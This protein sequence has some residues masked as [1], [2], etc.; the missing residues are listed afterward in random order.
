ML[1]LSGIQGPVTPYAPGAGRTFEWRWPPYA[2]QGNATAV[3]RLGSGTF[4]NSATGGTGATVGVGKWGGAP[5]TTITHAPGLSWVSHFNDRISIQT[6]RPGGDLLA[7]CNCWEVWCLAAFDIN[8]AITGDVGAMLH[9]FSGGYVDR[10]GD[11]ASAGVK[12]GPVGPGV[13]RF[14]MRAVN[15][16]PYSVDEAVAAAQTPNLSLFNKYAIRCVSGL[17]SQDPYVVA[18]LNDVEVSQRYSMT[19]AAGKFPAADAVSGANIGYE[20]AFAVRPGPAGL[21]AGAGLISWGIIAATSLQG[22]L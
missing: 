22:L 15:A 4:Q 14:R 13:V 21:N 9:D 6:E 1:R 10:D 7:W 19:A 11:A 12:F 3:G 2:G 5:A 8:A 16:G 20:P 17:A 18:L